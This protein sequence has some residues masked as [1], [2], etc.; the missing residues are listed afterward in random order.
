[1]ALGLGRP[2]VGSFTWFLNHAAHSLQE[3]IDA[4]RPTGAKGVY[5]KTMYVSTTM[6][7]SIKID[8]GKL[9]SMTVA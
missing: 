7:P 4:N 9:R 3:S 2:P 8:V 1:M 5:W 6:G